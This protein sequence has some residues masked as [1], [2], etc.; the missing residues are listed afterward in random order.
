VRTADGTTSVVRIVVPSSVL[1]QGVGKAWLALG[2]LGIILVLVS[3]LLADWLARSLVRPIAKLADVTGRLERG[4]LGARVQPGGP[5]EIAA[6]GQAVNQLAA[7]IG[8]LVAK[9]R[10]ATADLSHRLRTPL[11]ALRLDVEALGE[12][13]ERDRLMAD[14]MAIE[15]AV[16]Q[17]IQTA[18]NPEPK[19]AT[20]S[21]DLA[22]TVRRRLVFWTA[23]AR[24]QGRHCEMDIAGAVLPVAASESDLSAA[25]DTIVAN[26]FA[27]TPE[28]T[29]F[30]VQVDRAG[31]VARLVVE[32]DGPGFPAGMRL[33]RGRSGAGSTGLGLDIARRVAVQTGGRIRLIRRGNGGARVELHFGLTQSNGSESEISVERPALLRRREART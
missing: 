11:T 14:V 23:L 27:H 28:G 21:G 16:N 5:R 26:V 6:V 13:A 20:A 31:Q 30:S 8:D 2:A 22:A 3:V 12:Q 17:L 18:R 15:G 29:A 25:I 32:D 19:T 7:R 24:A 33:R 4:E 9:E 1:T 10:E